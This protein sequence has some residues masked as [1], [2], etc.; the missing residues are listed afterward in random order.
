MAITRRVLLV[1]CHGPTRFRRDLLLRLVLRH[2]YRG[3]T[4]CLKLDGT[5]GRC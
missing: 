3:A 5:A 4:Y 2:Q 1:A